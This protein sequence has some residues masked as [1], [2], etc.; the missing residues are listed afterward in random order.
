[1]QYTIITVCGVAVL[2]FSLSSGV[3]GDVRRARLEACSAQCRALRRRQHQANAGRDEQLASGRMLTCSPHLTQHVHSSAQDPIQMRDPHSVREPGRVYTRTV[4]RS[5]C[6]LC[7]DGPLSRTRSSFR[8]HPTDDRLRASIYHDCDFVSCYFIQ[9]YT[10]GFTA[11]HKGERE[12]KCQIY[13]A[14]LA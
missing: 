8:L 1:M 10:Y 12:S 4:C 11:Y 3:R 13:P 7:S 14:P 2:V 6:S 9:N 5:S